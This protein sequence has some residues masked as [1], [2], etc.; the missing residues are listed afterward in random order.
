MR[1]T[2][3]SV[4]L[5]SGRFE[6]RIVLTIVAGQLIGLSISTLLLTGFHPSDASLSTALGI[7]LSVVGIGLAIK[8]S[9]SRTSKRRY[10]IG[11]RLVALLIG[12]AISAIAVTYTSVGGGVITYLVLAFSYPDLDAPTLIGVD[13]TA[14]LTLCTI[15]SIETIATG[16]GEASLMALIAIGGLLGCIVGERVK[17][18]VP[19]RPLK[20]LIAVVI[21]AVGLFYL[22]KRGLVVLAVILALSLIALTTIARRIPIGND[23]EEADMVL[24]NSKNQLPKSHFTKDQLKVRP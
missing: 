2:T 21:G 22:A 16:R 7:A 10:P 20:K 24:G 8:E 18:K 17:K 12:G 13:V 23:E 11:M 14:S 5:R 19:S 6:K 9:M 15:A 3:S 1:A 4:S